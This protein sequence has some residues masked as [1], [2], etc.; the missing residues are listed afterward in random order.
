MF[1]YERIISA[2]QKENE[3]IN[4][5][6]YYD[7]A[8]SAEN[9]FFRF[10]DL[11]ENISEKDKALSILLNNVIE[12]KKNYQ[13]EIGYKI[14]EAILRNTHHL[15]KMFNI[16]EMLKKSIY[17]LHDTHTINYKSLY[18]IFDLLNRQKERYLDVINYIIERFFSI[19]ALPTN[20][21]AKY[22]KTRGNLF[23]YAVK[24]MEYDLKT[25]AR[26]I[27]S[28]KSRSMHSIENQIQRLVEAKKARHENLPMIE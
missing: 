21:Q 24:H 27:K 14:I 18:K 19:T 9:L 17:I 3:L 4:D 6:I 16:N 23:R 22:F 20:F 15:D 25:Y 10:L 26:H 1:N 11:A 28:L 12:R 5:L 2:Q 13:I 8:N 7:N